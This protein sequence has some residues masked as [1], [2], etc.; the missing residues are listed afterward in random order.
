M[1]VRVYP[2]DKGGCGHYRLIWPAL[3]LQQKGYDVVVEQRRPEV[4]SMG[5]KIVGLARDPNCDVV[6]FQRPARQ[7]YVDI[8]EV[9]RKQGVRVIVDMDDD[10]TCIH[11]SNS[12]WY[13]YQQQD[14]NWRYALTACEKADLVVCA[15]PALAERYG[16]N[17]VV[18]PNH[19]P[20]RYLEIEG[21]RSQ[22][23]VTIGWAGFVETHPVDLQITH[24]AVNDA[25][26][27]S[28]D[29]SRF[30]TL[31][32]E[33]A[34]QNLGI[35]NRFPHEVQAGVKLEEYPQAL[36]QFD[37]G[38]V[39]L[40][41]SPFNRAKS[42]L[43][44][45]EYAACG[46]APIVSPTPDNLNLINAGAALSAASPAE[47]KDN[48]RLL[49]EDAEARKAL[50]ETARAFAATKTIDLNAELWWNAWTSVV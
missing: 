37:I 20:S 50:V 15:T 14:M 24:G 22:D 16:K 31:G 38:I 4:L 46:I 34:L 13:P 39:P 42:W 21:K 45:L 27:T 3:A 48:L 41:N 1:R 2:Q 25:L 49:I 40:E 26:S 6:V 23:F 35:R 5:N 33:K 47:W 17:Q 12:A 18:V 8:F 10:L 28:K 11:P 44:G 43:K 30:V 29:P 32:T 9:Y 19:V 36:A 7:Q